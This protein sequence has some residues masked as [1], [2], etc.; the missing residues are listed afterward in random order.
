MIDGRR[1]SVR[2][3]WRGIFGVI[4]G[5]R[6]NTRWVTR[7]GVV[8]MIS[9]A[10]S[11]GCLGSLFVAAVCITGWGG[12]PAIVIGLFFVVGV[13]GVLVA[14]CTTEL[15]HRYPQNAG[16]AA[17]MF[18]AGQ[19]ALG[20]IS[21]LIVGLWQSGTPLGMGTTIGGTGLL[22]YVGRTMVKRQRSASVQE[23]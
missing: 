22:C 17:A 11:I 20:A 6:I 1:Q 23:A 9:I 16:A 15:M 21:S 12:L 13:V 8:R 18:G 4:S 7:L 2:I 5:N 10:A 3:V 14:N 19:L